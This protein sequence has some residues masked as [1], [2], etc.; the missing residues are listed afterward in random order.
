MFK[1][2]SITSQK[3]EV[4]TGC[5][6]VTP[7]W[8]FKLQTFRPD[9]YTWNFCEADTCVTWAKANNLRIRGNCLLW[10]LHIPNWIEALPA[11]QLELQLKNY[12]QTIVGRYPEVN[13]WDVANELMADVGVMRESVWKHIPDVVERAFLWAHEANPKALLFYNDYRPMAKDK[14]LAIFAYIDN[15]KAKNI[16]IHGIGIQLH[17]HL[18]RCLA[19]GLWGWASLKWVVQEARSRNLL[20]E[21]TEVSVLD[22]LGMP[23]SREKVLEGLYAIA[24]ELDVLGFTMWHW[25]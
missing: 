2:I 8:A 4:P 23:A 20:V 10:H 14:W 13:S 24:Q 19:E 15:L 17:H 3:L 9:S 1:G 16:P 7:A 22:D 6:S 25:N 21:F 12:I 11:D 18:R 5:T